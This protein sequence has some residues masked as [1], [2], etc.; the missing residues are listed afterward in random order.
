MKLQRFFGQGWVIAIIAM[1]IGFVGGIVLPPSLQRS[2]KETI[3]QDTR[4][5]GN[6]YRFISPLLACADEDLTTLPNDK[7]NAL[8]DALSDLSLNRRTP[9]RFPRQA[10][11]SGN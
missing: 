8:E 3:G 10:C 5:L 1:T 11:T 7:T 9:E 6:Q 2:V 4:E